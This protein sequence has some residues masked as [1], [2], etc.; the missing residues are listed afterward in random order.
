MVFSNMIREIFNQILE[1]WK[2]LSGLMI[3]NLMQ[4]YKHAD[5]IKYSFEYI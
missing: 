5:N 2:N 4:V 1:N 3:M